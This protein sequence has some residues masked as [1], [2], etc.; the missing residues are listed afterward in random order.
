MGKCEPIDLGDCLAG[1]DAKRSLVICDCEGY[2]S[3]LLD[4]AL[5]PQLVHAHMLVELHERRQPGVTD[6]L[7]ARFE[8][9][10]Q[11][12]QIWVEPRSATDFPIRTLYTR[13]L[14]DRFLVNAIDE[15]RNQSQSWLWI[16]PE[17]ALPGRA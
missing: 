12:E 14:P 11:I 9:S 3:V 2:E 10:H 7:K 15:W 1:R 4:P 8:R 6:L 16:Q 13:L 17:G 5:V